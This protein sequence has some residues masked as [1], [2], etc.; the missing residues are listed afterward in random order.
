MASSRPVGAWELTAAPTVHRPASHQAS[1]L[2][3]SSPERR[4][5][6]DWKMA[7]ALST[8]H[9][10]ARIQGAEFTTRLCLSMR[11]IKL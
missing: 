7:R 4:S 8:G 11:F 2:I 5:Q 1:Q 9:G 3:L 10:E 6:Q